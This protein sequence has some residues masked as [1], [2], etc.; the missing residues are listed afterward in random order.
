MSYAGKLELKLKAQKLRKKGLSVGRIQKQLG[1]SRSS[2]SLW[3]RNVKLTDRQIKKLYS[4]K[5]SG[6]LKGSF[7]AARNKIK[8]RELLTQGIMEAARKDIKALSRRDRFMAGVVMY[9]AE[10]DKGGK[11]ASFS[12]SDPRAIK[13]MVGWFREECRV[14]EGKFR[15]YL[16]IHDNLNE[17]KAKCFWSNLT[18][19]PLSQFR[20]SYIVKNNPKR[21]RKVRHEYGVLRISVSDVNLCRKIM[22]WISGIFDVE[23]SPIPR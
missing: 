21:L 3:V 14:P 16:Y 6:A 5:R 15:C 4:N 1:V 12:N 23:L 8:A 7:I 10:G 13:F 17:I 19:I 20:K 22:G 2:V 18:S 11:N 9:F